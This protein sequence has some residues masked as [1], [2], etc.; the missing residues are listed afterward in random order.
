MSAAR[1]YTIGHSTRTLEELVALLQEHGVLRLA[2]VRRFPGSRRHPQFSREALE[3]ELPGYGIAYE[4]FDSLGGRRKPS[5]ESR[6]A[7]LHN[8]QFRG[9]ADHMAGD[10]FRET[11]DRLLGD[12]RPTA[13]MCAEAVPWRCHRN[14]L[15][16]DATRRGVEVVHIMSPGKSSLHKL[17]KIAK[18]EGDAVIYPPPQQSL[19]FGGV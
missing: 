19:D 2:D 4:H 6:N 1:L 9:Y 16:D 10:E 5:A 7:A 12:D 14:L 11:M 18:I 17:H 13:V 15:A 8:D 3:R